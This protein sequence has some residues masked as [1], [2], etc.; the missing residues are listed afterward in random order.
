MNYLI[1]FD[2]SNKID[3]FSKEFS[4]YGAY[5][6]SDQSLAVI[7][8]KVR[9]VF[10][11][12]N[13]KSELHF[14]EYSKDTNIKKYFQA[15]HTV[16]NENIRLNILIVNN[17]DAFNSADNI[18]LTT[19]ELRNLFYIKIPERLFYGLT[20]D[21][22]HLETQGEIVSVKIKIDK[23]GEYDKIDL[24][25]KIVE[26]MNAHSAYRNKNYRVDKVSQQD[27]EKSLP[28]QIIDTFMGIV[29]FLLEKTYLENSD[30]S[31]I[32]SDLIY[33]FLIEQDNLFRF[34]NQVR[35]FKWTGHEEL[36][37]INIAEHL[38]PF[39]VHKTNFDIQEMNKIQKMLLENPS[40]STKDLRIQLGYP[41]T[42]LRQ[43]LG[44]K[45]QLNNIGRN[46][47]LLN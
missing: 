19:P 33:R 25:D 35:L 8:K 39:M 44:Y 23:N 31:K 12:L 14:R 41:N 16:I 47:F 30:T 42:M 43:L 34:Q 18:G 3:Q 1:Y 6:G 28:L 21:L 22:S 9:A 32:K 37:Q 26:Q 7:V 45:D 10:K 24:N 27:S 38:S 15:L 2:E 17:N 46:T 20:R 5:G 4:Y 36:L 29:V 40:I 11:K 13:S